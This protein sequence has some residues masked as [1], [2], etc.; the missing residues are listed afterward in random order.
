MFHS[1]LINKAEV[2]CAICEVL[3]SILDIS[4]P[5]A[6]TTKGIS[7]F[8]FFFFF[9]LAMRQNVACVPSHRY[10]NEPS[11]A[12]TRWAWTFAIF[13]NLTLASKNTR[14]SGSRGS[15]RPHM[16]GWLKRHCCYSCPHCLHASHCQGHLLQ[17]ANTLPCAPVYCSP[18]YVELLCLPLRLSLI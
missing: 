2:R 5:I 7:F 11:W 13:P 4:E 18:I 1:S 14:G 16:C 3:R 9:H 15:S 17:H 8:F 6:K 10:S 12:Q